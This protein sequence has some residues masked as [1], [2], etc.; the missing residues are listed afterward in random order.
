[1]NTPTA[2]HANM[3]AIELF[4][5]LPVDHCKKILANSRERRFGP[6]EVIF[7]AGDLRKCIFLLLEGRVKITQSSAR[8]GDVIL[9]INLPGQVIGSLVLSPE[10]T[11]SSTARA[12]E[13]CQAVEWDYASCESSLQ[14]HPLLV[15]NAQRIIARQYGELG[16]RIREVST[17]CSES[18]LAKGLVRLIAQIGRRVHDRYELNLSQRDLAQMTAVSHYTANRQLREWQRQGLLLRRNR[19]IVILD[20]PR[21]KRLAALG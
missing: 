16:C 14:E 2:V 1:M 21:L 17:E 8:G 4:E 13:F 11:H 19:T 5:G 6:S 18:R 10:S 7:R 12:I 3:P 15:R 9:F 20:L